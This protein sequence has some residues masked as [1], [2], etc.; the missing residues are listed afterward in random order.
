M[1]SW[2]FHEDQDQT[3]QLDLQGVWGL[4][5]EHSQH[6]EDVF[7]WYGKRFLMCVMQNTVLMTSVRSIILL[8]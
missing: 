8:I 4:G 5:M 1:S 2:Y 6:M 7:I 3:M